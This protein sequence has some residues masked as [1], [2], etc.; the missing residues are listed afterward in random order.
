[1]PSPGVKARI[2]RFWRAVKKLQRFSEISME[3]FIESEDVI[4]AAERNLHIAV[5]AAIDL[6]EALIAYMRWRSPRSYREIA[7][8]FLENKAID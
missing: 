6:G 5:E 4:D 2:D 3:R 8:I 7:T 1:M